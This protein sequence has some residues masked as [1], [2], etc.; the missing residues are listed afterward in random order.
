METNSCNSAM[1]LL[2]LMMDTE[3]KLTLLL[4]NSSTSSGCSRW[5]RRRPSLKSAILRKKSKL[6]VTGLLP[7]VKYKDLFLVTC[8]FSVTKDPLT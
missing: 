2:I 5:D 3:T 6:Q 4:L 1:S 8:H 7:E